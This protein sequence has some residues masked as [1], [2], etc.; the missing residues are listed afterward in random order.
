MIL[1]TGASGHVGGELVARLAA[2]GRP[3]RALVRDT[4]KYQ[5]S[6]GVEAVSGDMDQ[7]SSMAAAFDGVDAAFLLGGFA[8]MPGVLA[9]ARDAGVRHV[10]LPSSR[11]VVGGNPENA[12]VAM[13]M[14][15]EAAIVESGLDW[16][17][18][19]PSGFMSNTLQW[20]PQL[21]N[22]D[23]VRDAFGDVPIA[24]IDPYDIAAVA[25]A[26]LNRPEHFGRSHSLSGPAALTPSARVA[27]LAKVLGR[28]LRF[29]GKGDDEARAEMLQSIPEQYVDAFFRFFSDGE[30]DD[31]PILT[32]VEDITGS[33]P[34][35]FEAWASVHAAAFG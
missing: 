25:A 30:F 16:T 15:S 31:T 10:V 13:H 2:V 18:L 12:V 24:V 27:V 3:V 4:A 19:R 34:R 22:G 28:P 35:D 7:P 29:E 14:G 20:L 8:D 33:A 32:A 17:F 11:S 26:V 9:V 23:L 5:A 6:A 1:V 21:R